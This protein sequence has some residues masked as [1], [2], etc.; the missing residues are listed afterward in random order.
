MSI[1]FSGDFHANAENELNAIT[2]KSLI[3]KYK[4]E[5]YHT[6]KYHIIL[7]DGGFLWPGNQSTDLYNYTV[8]AHRPFPIL[9]VIGNHEPILGMRDMPETDIGIGET[10]YQ[11]QEVPFVAY[12]KRGKVYTIDGFRMLVLGGALSIDKSRRRPN[13]SWWEQEYWSA[14]EKDD[15]FKLIETESTFDCV[16]AHTGPNLINEKLFGYKMYYS[17]KFRDEVAHLND[18]ICRRIQFRE[19]WCGHWHQDIYYCDNETGRGYRYLYQTTK[20]LEKLDSEMV[21]HNELGMATR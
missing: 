9:C 7:G 14:S 21:I 19:W 6:I 16:L 12:L 1:L 15:V 2:K 20:I 10:V 17:K 13:I 18:E 5:K 8:L 4:Q 11:I 3:Q